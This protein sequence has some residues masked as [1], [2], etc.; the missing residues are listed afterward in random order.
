MAN[1]TIKQIRAICLDN[2]RFMKLK[3][4]MCREIGG[5]FVP[6]VVL[7]RLGRY[8]FILLQYSTYYC[9]IFYIDKLRNEKYICSVR[10]IL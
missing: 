6:I 3:E 7:E 1:N 10:T 8:H 5:K 4:E 9:D 2:Q